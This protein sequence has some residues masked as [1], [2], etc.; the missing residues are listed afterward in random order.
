MQIY[1]H[2]DDFL[3]EV[4]IENKQIVCFGA[5]TIPLLIEPLFE[6]EGLWK[7]IICFLDNDINKA[8][9]WIGEKKKIPIMTLMQFREQSL[10]EFIILITCEA[11]VNIIQQL[12]EIIEWTDIHCY[13]YVNLNYDLQMQHKGNFYFNKKNE[14]S[15][16]KT[17]HYCWFGNNKKKDLHER[18]IQS[19]K[20]KCPDYEIIEW[21]E[22]NYN[23]HKVR[24]MSE[25]YKC[26]KWAFVADYAR[27]DILYDYGG[28]YLD[29][30]VEILQNL[31]ILLR[32][33][34]FIAYGQWPAVNSGAGIGSAKNHPLI[35]EMRDIPRATQSF[36]NKDGTLNLVQNGY[37][38]SKVLRKYGFKQDF[39]MQYVGDFL[40][41][42]PEYMATASVLGKDVFLTE[43]SLSLHHCDGSWISFNTLKERRQTEEESG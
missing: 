27:L 4:N 39:T 25:A 17:I 30:D 12:N 9:K 1:T 26:G 32:E 7:K 28:I 3:R 29:T 14:I 8:G 36:I 37:Y 23:V 13:I 18:C 38:E 2:W 22:T 35:A 40:V 24:Y 41:L 42:A 15:I 21:N 10:K 5:G 6:K 16:P 31:D 19:W 11:Y 43:N 20:T 33:K 34:G